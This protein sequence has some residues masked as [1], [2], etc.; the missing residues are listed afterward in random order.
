MRQVIFQEIFS[1]RQ[2]MEENKEPLHILVSA[3]ACSPEWGSEVGMGW[4]WVK[5]LSKFCQLDVI[6]E[7]G[8]ATAINQAVANGEIESFVPK[9]HYIDIGEKGR[10]LF[11]AQGSWGFY[12]F[13]RKWQYAAFKCAEK[14]MKDQH[15][16]VVHQLNMV[17]FREPGYLWKLSDIPYFWGPVCGMG[18]VP[19][20]FIATLDVKNQIKYHIKNI[21][22]LIHQYTLPRVAKAV[23]RADALFAVTRVEQQ[24][25][26]RRYG[27]SSVILPEV[28]AE[29]RAGV[30]RR[31]EHDGKLILSWCGVMEGRKA[32]NIVLNALAKVK[33]KS[34]PSVLHIIGDGPCR[35]QWYKL[36]QKLGLEQQCVWHGRI[37]HEK[38]L[39]I[40]G[41]SDVFLFSSWKEATSTVINEALSLGVGVICHDA[42]GM[43]A[44]IDQSCG[45]KIALSSPED[46][47]NGF[48]EKIEAIHNDR[49][50]ISD[51]SAG[52]L[53]RAGELSWENNAKTMFNYYCKAVGK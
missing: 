44:A 38:S 12:Y 19:G 17:G 32:L 14:L 43:G 8:F 7:A 25:F 46:S 22:N 34:I 33:A 6:T 24:I 50:K 10:K 11:W 39:E 52:A 2:N 20:K 9:F 53:K 27:K 49:K 31:E 30:V 3:Y 26:E 41:N 16:D 18:W 47:I 36:C 40:I 5:A 4:H 15:F 13:Y 1:A 21:I 48:A 51:L 42:C 37:P 45:M 28:G 35:A 29:P 23:R